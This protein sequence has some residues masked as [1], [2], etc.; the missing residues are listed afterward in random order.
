MPQ[1]KTDEAICLFGF[2]DQLHGKKFPQTATGGG[3][4]IALCGGWGRST[5]CNQNGRLKTALGLPTSPNTAT[6]WLQGTAPATGVKH[7]ATS[8]PAQMS[9]PASG[10][11]PSLCVPT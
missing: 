10:R 5:V 11:L 3:G 8:L 6:M 1:L 7:S 2:R 9:P 4:P